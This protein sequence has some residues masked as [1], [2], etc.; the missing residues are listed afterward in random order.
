M[1]LEIGK[2]YKTRNNTKIKIITKRDFPTSWNFLGE[3]E[4]GYVF[5]FTKYGRFLITRN[6]QLDLITELETVKPFPKY[7]IPLKEHIKH[8]KVLLDEMESLLENTEE[9]LK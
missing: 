3:D 9:L 5:S 2:T 8:F 1:L 7:L 6:H 4:K